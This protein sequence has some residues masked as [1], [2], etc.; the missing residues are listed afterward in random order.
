MPGRLFY[1]LQ[2]LSLAAVLTGCGG[3]SE[4]RTGGKTQVE[5]DQAIFDDPAS[6]GPGS[7]QATADKQAPQ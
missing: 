7:K 6:G 5:T 1:A 3:Q 4:P 2:W